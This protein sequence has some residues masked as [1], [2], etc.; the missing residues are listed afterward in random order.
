MYRLAK[1][2]FTQ[3]L[4]VLHLAQHASGSSS[5]YFDRADAD[6]RSREYFRPNFWPNTPDILHAS[7]CR[8][9]AAPA[10]VARLVLAATLS[11]SYGIYGPAFELRRAHAARAGQR[12]VPR[13]REVPDRA[14]GPRRRRQPARR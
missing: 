11:S 10:F 1:L 14:L 4:H 5:E 7:T 8:T 3:S 2:G 12:G 9:A 13:L 6:R